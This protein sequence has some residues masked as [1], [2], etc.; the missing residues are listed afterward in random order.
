[1]NLRYLKLALIGLALVLFS[2][3]CFIPPPPPYRQHHHHRYRH[4]N[5]LQQSPKS[6]A[7]LAIQNGGEFN[8]QGEVAH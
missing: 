4:G 8:D 5:S 6:V 3:G 7:Q 2:Q 1:M